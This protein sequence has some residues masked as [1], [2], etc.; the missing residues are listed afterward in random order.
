M[1]F[2]V[3]ELPYY[4]EFCPLYGMCQDNASESN[5]PRYW[6]KDKVCSDDNP[7]ECQLLAETDK[8][9]G[10]NDHRCQTCKHFDDLDMKFSCDICYGYSKWEAKDE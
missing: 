5:C 9:M 6:S 3:N 8:H 4:E 7:H 2:I 10:T 1:K